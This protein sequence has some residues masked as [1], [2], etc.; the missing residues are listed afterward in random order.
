[1]GFETSEDGSTEMGNAERVKVQLMLMPHAAD[2]P[3]P[4]NSNEGLDLVAAILAPMVIAPG[5]RAAIPTGL[6][7]E[8]PPGTEGQIRSRHGLVLHFGVIVLASPQTIASTYRGEVHVILQNLGS[9]PYKV[10]RG[11]RI[12]LLAI[13]PTPTVDWE[14][15]LPAW[16]EENRGPN[17]EK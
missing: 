5:H 2:L 3:A 9:H 8:L 10:E 14:W 17:R 4:T 1:V 7:V 15:P 16:V 6:V 13:A 12:A 11:A